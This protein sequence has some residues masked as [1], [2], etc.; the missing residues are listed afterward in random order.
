MKL[1][2]DFIEKW[3]HIISDVTEK[4]MIPLECIEK[5]IIKYQPRRR[6][7]IN[8]KS[9]KRQGLELEEIEVLLTRHLEDLG[10]EVTDLEFIVDV[11]AVAEI[12]Q[13]ETNRIL[14]KL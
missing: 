2:N 13:P 6:K 1:S 7:T 4:T 8:F 3:E 14:E 10:D 9:L 12:I 5:V 11:H